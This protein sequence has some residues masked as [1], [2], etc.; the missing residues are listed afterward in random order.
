MLLFAISNDAEPKNL[1]EDVLKTS[2]LMF[3]LNN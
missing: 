3:N 1:K 2:V